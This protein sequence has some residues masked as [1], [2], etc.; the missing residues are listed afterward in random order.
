M[1]YNKLALRNGEVMSLNTF[2][3]TYNTPKGMTI[4]VIMMLVDGLPVGEDW[5]DDCNPYAIVAI[6]KYP[7]GWGWIELGSDTK[8]EIGQYMLDCHVD[9]GKWYYLT[10]HKQHTGSE[11]PKLPNL[12]IAGQVDEPETHA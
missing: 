3:P 8:Y 10:I 2:P 11:V 9:V 4:K 5:N 6:D 7:Q 12:P 1:T